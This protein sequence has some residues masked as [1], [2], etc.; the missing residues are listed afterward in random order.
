MQP[1]GQ[2]RP[3]SFWLIQPY[4]TK[5]GRPVF[6]LLDHLDLAVRTSLGIFWNP[7]ARSCQTG[8][9]SKASWAFPCTKFPCLPHW[10]MF[11][12]DLRNLFRR[13]PVQSETFDTPCTGKRYHFL[14]S[15]TSAMSRWWSDDLHCQIANESGPCPKSDLELA[16][17]ISTFPWKIES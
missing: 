6:Y 2:I 15:S 8:F 17:K 16:T 9:S 1:Y 10:E 11:Q 7:I 12:V 4:G 3:F 14:K 5:F 13:N